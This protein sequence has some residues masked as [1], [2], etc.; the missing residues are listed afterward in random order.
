MTIEPGSTTD[1]VRAVSLFAAL[2]GACMA[3]GA[4]EALPYL[5][6][7]RAEL[8]DYGQRLLANFVDI[9]VPSFCAGL[10]EL[11]ELLTQMRASSTDLTHT[12]GLDSVQ[13]LL[14]DGMAAMQ[15]AAGTA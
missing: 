13:R 10:V 1:F 5:G 14:R 11:D 8:T 2:E 6:M 4:S 9:P 15:D 7:A 3:S 12:L